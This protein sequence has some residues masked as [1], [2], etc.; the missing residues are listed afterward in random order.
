MGSLEAG[1][2]IIVTD[3][4]GSELGLNNG[5]CIIGLSLKVAYVDTYLSTYPYKVE[6]NDRSYWVEGLP[7]SP[8]MAELI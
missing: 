2:F 3:V 7:Y 5:Y 1:D 6:Y 8:L 4:L